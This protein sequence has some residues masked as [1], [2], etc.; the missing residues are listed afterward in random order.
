[1]T[2]YLYTFTKGA[3]TYHLTITRDEGGYRGRYT[4]PI[5]KTTTE[6]DR[7]YLSQ[8]EAV[9]KLQAVVYA[10]HHAPIHVIG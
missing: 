1:M 8:Q 3:V 10:Q 4:C 6:V 5:C 9:L 7:Q 2:E